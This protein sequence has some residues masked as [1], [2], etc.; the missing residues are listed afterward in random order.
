MIYHGHSHGHGQWYDDHEQ[1]KCTSHFKSLGQMSLWKGG[2]R[3][4]HIVFNAK[5]QQI[6]K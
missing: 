4:G 6:F 3:L 1:E 2:L 5:K